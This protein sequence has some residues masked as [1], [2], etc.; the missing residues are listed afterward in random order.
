L[1]D[2]PKKGENEGGPNVEVGRPGKPRRISFGGEAGG[3]K[4]PE[5]SHWCELAKN[6]ME[7]MPRPRPSYDLAGF[8]LLSDAGEPG[9]GFSVFMFKVFGA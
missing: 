3:V 1:R 9:R 4:S 6:K 5:E 8:G 2:T 7:K